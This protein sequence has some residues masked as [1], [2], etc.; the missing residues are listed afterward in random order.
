M[1]KG[2]TVNRTKSRWVI[3]SQMK[4]VNEAVDDWG[5]KYPCN[6]DEDHAAVHSIE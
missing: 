5:E 1:E 6:N 4:V 3:H 2:A